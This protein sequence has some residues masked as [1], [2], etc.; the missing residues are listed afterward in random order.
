MND[1]AKTLKRSEI[2]KQ[3]NYNDPDWRR[4]ATITMTFHIAWFRV[5]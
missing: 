3:V 4:H 1:E 5:T 2:E